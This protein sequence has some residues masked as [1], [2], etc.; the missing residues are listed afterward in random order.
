MFELA[1]VAWLIGAALSVR[2]GYFALFPALLFLLIFV[3][4]GE[5]S[6]GATMWSAGA[7]ML[8]VALSTQ[9]GYFAGSVL[10]FKVGD[11]HREKTVLPT[12][13]RRHSG[14]SPR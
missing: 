3:A 13:P 4:L 7:T 6:R 14:L 1:V 5:V 11:R 2:F 12:T 10:R 9:L 8:L